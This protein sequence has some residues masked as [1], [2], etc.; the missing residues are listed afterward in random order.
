M[1]KLLVC[2]L[3]ISFC[4]G[5]STPDT[6]KVFEGQGDRSINLENLGTEFML[7][8]FS[9]ESGRAYLDSNQGAIDIEVDDSN[10]ERTIPH[11]F[12]GV[13]PRGGMIYSDTD[14]KLTFK[15]LSYATVLKDE[16][17][18]PYDD[19]LKLFT[20]TNTLTITDEI[21]ENY[22]VYG[23]N[24]VGDLIGLEFG[25]G[26]ETFVFEENICYVYIG[27]NNEKTISTK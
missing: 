11:N 26:T 13:I 21:Y 6:W 22:T 17:T 14:W 19:V 25:L 23:F 27:T 12:N 1:K 15:P 20:Q 5:S 4:G 24:C 3:L 8:N 2:F 18:I 9:I 7:L 10:L 16:L